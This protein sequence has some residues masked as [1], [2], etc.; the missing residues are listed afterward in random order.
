MAKVSS[1]ISGGNRQP[2]GR[3]AVALV[4]A[5]V[6]C[7]LGSAGY[8]SHAQDAAKPTP[9]ATTPAMPPTVTP[10]SSAGTLA[11]VPP[12]AARPPVI[13]AKTLFGAA[14]G[15]APMA[16]RAIGSYSRGCLAGAKPLPVDGPQWQAMRLS[17]NR[18][19]GTPALIS[20]LER[21]ADDVHR[22]DGWPGLLVGDM[23]QPRGGPMVSSHNS[24]QVGLDVD[25]WYS[26]MPDHRLTRREREETSA[27]NLV[28][29]D[30]RGV[31]PALWGIDYV[32]LLKRAA[33]F[34]EVERIFVNPAIKKALCEATVHDVD[35]NWLSKM[36]PMWGHDDHFHVRIRCPDGMAGCTAQPPPAAEDGCGKEVAAWLA[37]VSRPED[38]HAK[39]APPATP[40]TMEKLPAECRA[41]LAAAP[42]PVPV[43]AKG[44][45]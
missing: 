8:S 7:T 34:G 2:D 5:V 16:A 23:S 12:V 38:P 24:H 9:A 4:I 32:L 18:N 15:P 29:P 42:G 30:K 39:P 33:S 13:A 20:F 43:A 25:I 35:R 40:L 14:K 21:F 27:I 26:P 44:K 1:A 28:M 45:P 19:W 10:P 37:L 22:L 6:A 3:R 17:R 31:N 36:R 41:V 11:A